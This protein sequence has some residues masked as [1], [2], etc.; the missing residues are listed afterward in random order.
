[1]QV[2]TLGSEEWK[3]VAKCVNATVEG[4]FFR[5]KDFHTLI[6]MWCDEARATLEKNAMDHQ[7]RYLYLANNS[8]NNLVGY[9]HKMS[10]E[11]VEWTGLDRAQLKSLFSRFREATGHTLGTSYVGN[12]K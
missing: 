10:V 11:L 3:A 7:G 12:L 9:P 2:T 5:D 8:M 4:P 1:M 6:G